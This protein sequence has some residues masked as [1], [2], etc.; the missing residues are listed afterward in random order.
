MTG[1]LITSSRG[2][3][4]YWVERNANPDAQC[5]VFTHG[6]TVNH[7][8]FDQQFAYFSADYTVITWDVPLHGRSHPYTY[9]SYENAAAE[10]LAILDRENIARAV[11]VGHSMGGYIC[12]EFAA[13]YPVRTQAFIAV[14][15]S[16][17]GCDYYSELDRRLLMATPRMSRYFPERMLCTMMARSCTHTRYGYHNALIMMEQMGKRRI[18]HAMYAAYSDIFTRAQP[19]QFDCPV[20]LILGEYDRTGKIAAYTREWAAKTGYPL[21]IISDAAHS[22]N[23]DNPDAFNGTVD[24]FLKSRCKQTVQ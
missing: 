8:Q 2:T 20:L 3:T 12:Q 4:Y 1:K 24:A 13:R 6:L 5:I 17:L 10:L 14:D 19:V 9:F 21:H 7:H 16:P 22:A 15:T 11:L 23:A 18:I